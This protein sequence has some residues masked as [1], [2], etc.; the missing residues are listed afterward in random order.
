MDISTQ[1]NRAN[2]IWVDLESSRS[3]IV[4][5]FFFYILVGYI[6]FNIYKP[7]LLYS[8]GYIL[9]CYIYIS[10]IVRKINLFFFVKPARVAE[11]GVEIDFYPHVLQDLCSL[12][13]PRYLFR[14]LFS[15]HK[16]SLVFLSWP[17]IRQIFGCSLFVLRANAHF[18][19]IKLIGPFHMLTTK[20]EII[21]KSQDGKIYSQFINDKK[22]CIKAINQFKDKELNS[23]QLHGGVRWSREI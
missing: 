8:P 4:F 16:K 14:N 21:I 11:D 20:F 17:E 3:W 9:C 7:G 15:Q 18:L 5:V 23:V 12:Y 1:N 6:L 10:M 22:G 2:I 19:M 13:S